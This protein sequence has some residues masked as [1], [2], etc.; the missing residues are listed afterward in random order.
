VNIDSKQNSRFDV[1]G[2][3]ASGFSARLTGKR[4]P[5]KLFTVKSKI[6]L[7][8]MQNRLLILTIFTALVAFAVRC[9]IDPDRPLM[10]REER[11]RE[12]KKDRKKTWDT[13][14]SIFRASCNNEYGSNSTKCLN[15]HIDCMLWTHTLIGDSRRCPEDCEG[16][17]LVPAVPGQKSPR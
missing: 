9:N 2:A 15:E 10:N 17:T 14:C 7:P 4:T 5:S 11:E 3:A 12:L 1:P 16:P 13:V 6:A 8:F